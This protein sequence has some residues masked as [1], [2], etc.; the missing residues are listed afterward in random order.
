MTDVTESRALR[1]LRDI[2]ESGRPLAYV[3]SAEERRI[4]ALLREAAGRSKPALPVWTWSLT[5]GMRRDGAK[6]GK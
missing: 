1:S 4:M 5:E 3:R 2:T 6:S